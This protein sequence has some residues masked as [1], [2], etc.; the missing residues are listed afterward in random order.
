MGVLYGTKCTSCNAIR[1][2]PS[3]DHA[4]M[5][6]LP[7]W[8]P[9]HPHPPDAPEEAHTAPNPHQNELQKTKRVLK[10]APKCI[11]QPLTGT[12][13]TK[14]K[15]L[16]HTETPPNCTIQTPKPTGVQWVHVLNPCFKECP[17]F[18]YGS[19]RMPS[20]AQ[21]PR[22][23]LCAGLRALCSWAAA[24][25]SGQGGPPQPPPASPPLVPSTGR[26]PRIGT[27]TNPLHPCPH[28]N[29]QPWTCTLGHV[30]G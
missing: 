19:S 25:P 5:P 24:T 6:C 9:Y 2:G 20:S 3:S 16:K 22:A 15:P 27:S 28:G 11:T 23:V 8:P 26:C 13:C 4:L 12:K 18:L 17:H 14:K 1:I 30:H 29:S 7:W 10:N 21:Q